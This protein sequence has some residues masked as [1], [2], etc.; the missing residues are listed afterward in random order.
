ML[1]LTLT[2]KNFR[3]FDDSD[4]AQL[5]LKSGVT[6]LVGPNNAGKSSL[7]RMFFEL[8]GLFALVAGTPGAVQAWLRGQNAGF[9]LAGVPDPLAILHDGNHRP[10]TLRIDCQPPDDERAVSSLEFTIGRQ[11]PRN[12]SASARAYRGRSRTEVPSGKPG[13]QEDFK[14]VVLNQE[15]D[16]SYFVEQTRALHDT[17]YIGP[18]RN[19]LNQS[20]AT[21]YD[22]TVGTDFVATWDSWKNGPNRGP[23]RAIKEVENAIA[24][25][26]GF[27]SLEINPSPGNEEL[28][29]FVNGQPFALHEQGAGLA[30]FIVTFGAAA[31][32]RPG[33]ILIDEPE[34]NLHPSLQIDFLTT[35]A[36]FAS[37]AV[38]FSTHSIGLARSMSD[39]IYS[40]QKRGSHSLLRPYEATPGLQE[41]AGELSF[42]AFREFGFDRLLLVEGPTD[43]R[44][45]QQLLRKLHKDQRVVVFPLLGHAFASGDCEAALLEL[46]RIAPASKIGALVDSER[47][48]PGGP[49]DARRNAFADACAKEGFSSVLLTERRAIENYFSRAAVQEGVGTQYDALNPYEAHGVAPKNWSKKLNWK[50]AHAMNLNDLEGTDLLRFLKSL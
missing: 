3:C 13:Q 33:L 10:M 30:Q 42:S 20:K 39:T 49:P 41:F 23:N 45:V 47:V 31:I 5:T 14:Y 25:L 27:S 44:T 19:I 7:L 6:A 29:V 8:R 38:L 36:T 46:R 1:D 11:S 32:R 15:I 34:L 16:F 2:I 12:A 37:E 50:I 17:L 4:P 18:F 21:Y 40:V 24:H 28:R 26:F 9:G 35:L 43:V 22:L 48:N